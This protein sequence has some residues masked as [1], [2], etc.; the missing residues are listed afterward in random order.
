VEL[1]TGLT[2]RVRTVW[3]GHNQLPCRSSDGLRQ[4]RAD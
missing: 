2:K 1:G 3:H 4:I